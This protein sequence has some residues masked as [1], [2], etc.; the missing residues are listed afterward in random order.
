MNEVKGKLDKFNRKGLEK[1]FKVDY[2]K[3][4]SRKKLI[5]DAVKATNKRKKKKPPND[6]PKKPK[7]K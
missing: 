7:K 1:S 2:K 3:A 4:Q 6:K 5:D